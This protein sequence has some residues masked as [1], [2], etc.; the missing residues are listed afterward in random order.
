M[1]LF[2][3]C[4]D[5]LRVLWRIRCKLDPVSNRSIRRK[6]GLYFDIHANWE[7]V[8]RLREECRRL[9]EQ[10][11]ATAKATGSLDGTAQLQQRLTESTEKLNGLVDCAAKTGAEV[12]N[13]LARELEA[14]SNSVGRFSG[15]LSSVKDGLDGYIEARRKSGVIM[16]SC[17][18]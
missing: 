10:I 8:V 14:S 1:F 13:G 16:V 7:E 12:R 11:T 17:S 5:A 15:V 6:S 9:E 4:F 2:L 3:T 18:F